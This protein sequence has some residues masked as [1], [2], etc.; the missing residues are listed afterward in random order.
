LG[1]GLL[2]GEVNIAMPYYVIEKTMEAL[3]YQHLRD[4]GLIIDRRNATKAPASEKIV[5]C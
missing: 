2:A 5:R 3:N 4:L 1:D